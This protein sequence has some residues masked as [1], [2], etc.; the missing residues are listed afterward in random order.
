ML[1]R[2]LLGQF[3]VCT[4]IK[5]TL[6]RDGSR[7]EPMSQFRPKLMFVLPFFPFENHRLFAVIWG[8]VSTDR[9]TVVPD[10]P[11][12]QTNFYIY[13]DLLQK[14]M[15]CMMGLHVK[16]A[17]SSP[18]G[19]ISFWSDQD[20]WKSYGSSQSVGLQIVAKF[21]DLRNLILHLWMLLY[22]P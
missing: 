20:P 21:A 3:F 1:S 22:G 8:R 11:Q 15:Y 10:L 16:D 18:V 14:Y 6:A 7:D 17:D 9:C 2:I 4:I 19:S 5:G 13:D 12:W